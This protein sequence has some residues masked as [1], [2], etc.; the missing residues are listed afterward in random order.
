[1]LATRRTGARGGRCS[2]LIS[3]HSLLRFSLPRLWVIRVWPCMQH[4]CVWRIAVCGG[5]P[6]S[7]P[8]QVLHRAASA[9]EPAATAHIAAAEPCGRGEPLHGGGD[10][11]PDQ[12]HSLHG[13]WHNHA[14]ER[15]PEGA[16][17]LHAGERASCSR[18]ADVGVVSSKGGLLPL[19]GRT[20]RVDGDAHPLAATDER[21]LH[22]LAR[23]PVG[24]E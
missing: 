5:L 2:S 9:N 19:I 20:V 18:S 15:F 11:G 24:S 23:P 13:L 21:A 6:F 16:R 22:A 14:R 10:D 3:H 17:D 8:V 12:R 7:C 1:M 4:G